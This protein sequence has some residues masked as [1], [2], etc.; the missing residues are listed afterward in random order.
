M[1]RSCK[2]LKSWMS[3][4]LFSLFVLVRIVDAGD[5]PSDTVIVP[6]GDHNLEFY[7]CHAEGQN[8]LTPGTILMLNSSVT[9][10]I[11]LGG[12]FCVLH[13]LTDL[14]ILSDSD[15]SYADVRCSVA[16]PLVFYV[17][18]ARGFAFL[19]GSRLKIQRISFT[20]CGGPLSSSFFY[21][22]TSLPVYFGLYQSV[23]LF[24]A[25]TLNLTLTDITISAYY[26]F[27]IVAVNALG[28]T[29]FKGLEIYNSLSHDMSVCTQ[30]THI[31]GNYSCYG[32]G[33]LI[34]NHDG[35]LGIDNTSSNCPTDYSNQ[36][37]IVVKDS[38]IYDN[39]NLIFDFLCILNVFQFQPARV[40]IVSGPALTIYATQQSFDSSV[41]LTNSV[42]F[43]NIGLI[44]GGILAIFVDTPF[45][46]SFTLSNVSLTNNT[47]LNVCVGKGF[48]SYIY[49]TDDFLTRKQKGGIMLTAQELTDTWTPIIFSN[50]TVSEHKG[51]RTS[52]T[53]Y[54][55]MRSQ[56]LYNVHV[57]LDNV[58]FVRNSATYTGVCFNAN[59]AYEPMLHSKRLVVTLRNI[60]ALNNSQ[61]NGVA[62]VFTNSSMFIF[63]RL[64]QVIIEGVDSYSSVFRN[65][66]GSVIDA[67]S[68]NVY[69]RGRISFINNT[70]STGPAILLRSGSFLV[71]SNE[72]SVLFKSNTAYVNGGAIYS[73]EEGTEIND[74]IIQLDI[75][76]STK[77][78]LNEQ[79][80]INLTFIDNLAF[81][82]GNSLYIRPLQHCFQTKGH[83]FPRNLLDL[84]DKIFHFPN[85]ANEDQM[86]SVPVTICKCN[87]T[88]EPDFTLQFDT[89]E[90]YPGQSLS[91]NIVALD[92]NNAPVQSQVN[93]S[94]SYN[95]SLVVPLPGWKLFSKQEIATFIGKKCQV[96]NYT[97]LSNLETKMGHL[98]LAVPGKSNYI[99]VP[100]KLKDCPP[101][102][103]LHDSKCK[104]GPFISNHSDA[105]SCNL[106]KLTVGTK[107]AS[108]WVGIVSLNNKSV[109]AYSKYCPNGYCNTTIT[110]LQLN[111]SNSSVCL[112]NREGVLCGNCKSGY[113]AV[114][115]GPQCKICSDRSLLWLIGNLSAGIILVFVLFVFKMTLNVGTVGGLIFYANVFV[116]ANAVPVYQYYNIPFVQLI[117]LLNMGQ[118]FPSC[119]YNGMQYYV[120]VLISFFYSL[121]LW[122][123]A[124]LIILLARCST[125]VAKLLMESSVQVLMTLIHLSL[126]K[127]LVASI[128][129]YLFTEVYTEQSPDSSYTV[130]LYNGSMHYG[131]GA[132]IP[133]LITASLFTSIVI[134]PYVAFS[135]FGWMCLRFYYVNKFRPFFDTIYGPYKDAY[136]YW[137]GLRLVLLVLIAVLTAAL[138]GGFTFYQY[139]LQVILLVVFTVF[140]AY[141][142]PFKTDWANILDTWCMINVLALIL[143]NMYHSYGG[144]Y[145]EFILFAFFIGSC[146]TIIGVFMYHVIK[147]LGCLYMYCKHKRERQGSQMWV[148]NHSTTIVTP[149]ITDKNTQFRE[150]LLGYMDSDERAGN[151]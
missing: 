106:N 97:I 96:F 112:Y 55:T 4:L 92:E 93:A 39:T 143:I 145:S 105:L 22:D 33:I 144:H 5:A 9:H 46:S 11:S 76:N 52:S 148:P 50:T 20:Q 111:D 31:R 56:P 26:G 151:Y 34:Y 16:S 119:L 86:S 132:H 104:C 116:I 109:L 102:L 29:S 24:F 118:A 8:K 138:T 65:N 62:S 44:S 98:N 67:F 122:L 64:D 136:R 135:L 23:T 35:C 147:R 61:S 45:T 115:G 36:N 121:Y 87:E 139:L 113:S 47:L 19:G 58:R 85:S 140:Q 123:I 54:V 101:G 114:H 66:L 150:S 42:I 57:L 133:L 99:Y 88:N 90:I 49:F 126:A 41:L 84:Y 127:I 91:V 117:Q 103:I 94:F 27:A 53:V 38:F 125:R 15:S 30:D 63:Y 137:F 37:S 28:D 68:T 81:V 70:A 100:I 18:T 73:V 21:N 146:S 95:R 69:L 72:T 129:V 75:I 17:E 6:N 14:T 120:T 7:L 10:H 107:E 83:V 82:A 60:I 13:N 3:L 124:G 1:T 131:T 71:F 32:S 108:A 48:V 25:H 74:C 59:T 149:R 142:K 130:W 77:R 80:N 141:L 2:V 12:S 51:N 40:P 89:V 78:V 110:T 134:I 128:D 43:D 79:L